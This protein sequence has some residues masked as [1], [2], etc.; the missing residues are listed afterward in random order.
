MKQIA[1]M[2]SVYKKSKIANVKKTLESIYGQTRK[3]DLFLVVDGPI[4]NELKSFLLLQPVELFFLEKNIGIPKA[5]NF[6]LQEILRRN[7]KYIARMDADDIMMPNR[8]KLQYDFMEKN[9]DIDVV[10]GYVEEFGDDF[11]YSKVV[12]YPLTH[13]QI[14][15]FFAKRV[16]LANVTTFFRRSFFEKA[17]LYPTSS[18]TNEDTLLWMNGFKTGCR[19]ANIP[20]VLVKV[21]VSKDFFARRGGFAKAWSDFRDRINVIH[22]LGYNWNAYFFALAMLGVNLTPGFIK[23][24]LYKKLR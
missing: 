2:I 6:L 10:G 20:E 4:E 22:S 23:K 7:Y 17:G 12:T 14:F 3:S 24:I 21:R 19:F 9:K 8:L 1:T 16:P 5:Y 13:E 15:L 11:E 18:P